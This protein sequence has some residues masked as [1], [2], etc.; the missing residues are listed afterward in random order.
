MWKAEQKQ[1]HKTDLLLVLWVN[2]SRRSV[3]E[4]LATVAASS[5][6]HIE[7][8]HGVVVQDHRVVRLNEA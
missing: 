7:V 2:A 5:L 3:E 4:A 1:T 6:Q 8:D